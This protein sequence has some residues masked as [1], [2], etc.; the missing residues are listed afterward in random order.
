[1]GKDSQTWLFTNNCVVLMR[2]FKENNKQCLRHGRRKL[3]SEVLLHQIILE[4]VSLEEAFYPDQCPKEPLPNEL[5]DEEWLEGPKLKLVL[6][7][8][9]P[10]EASTEDTSLLRRL[11]S[12][13]E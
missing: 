1:M 11:V 8:S 13:E 5:P 2:Y 4:D 10:Y 3:A 7:P 6:S 9:E 12:L